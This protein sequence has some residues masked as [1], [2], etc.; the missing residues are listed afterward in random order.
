MEKELGNKR[1][2]GFTLIEVLVVIAIMGLLTSFALVSLQSA[3]VS[4]RDTK[5]KIDIR[6]L[7]NAM[8]LY[9]LDHDTYPGDIYNGW[10]QTCKTASIIPTI[11]T[12]TQKLVSDNYLP[13]FPCD[14]INTGSTN[15]FG[16]NPP[17]CPFGMT[18]LG[19]FID[20]DY[21]GV[22]MNT[23]SGNCDQYCIFAYLERGGY[24]S[25]GNS[26]WCTAHLNNSR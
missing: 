9:Y 14:P 11:S 12:E 13:G 18:C 6:Q 22:P 1:K 19:Y 8:E 16:G 24:V 15:D 21:S 10:E 23:C 5:R 25:R 2:C 4:A 3:R 17:V 7:V 20:T 26:V